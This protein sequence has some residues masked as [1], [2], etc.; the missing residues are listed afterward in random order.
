[1]FKL[2][3]SVAQGLPEGEAFALVSEAVLG[4][5]FLNT[6]SLKYSP[7]HK[8]LAAFLPRIVSKILH[9]KLEQPKPK[10]NY[11]FFEAEGCSNTRYCKTDNKEKV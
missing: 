3:P 7:M 10:Q 11:C 8:A 9:R 4:V 5:N 2:R 6:T 1:M